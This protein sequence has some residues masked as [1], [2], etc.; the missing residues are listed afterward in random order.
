MTADDAAYPGGALS[1][2]LSCRLSL[3]SFI[4]LLSQHQPLEELSLTF[5]ASIPEETSFAPL[6]TL[7][8]LQPLHMHSIENH[9]A[10]VLLSVTDAQVQELRAHTAGGAAVRF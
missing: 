5:E 9:Q 4:T 7:P 6:Q 2:R 8:A 10:G 1:R 3:N